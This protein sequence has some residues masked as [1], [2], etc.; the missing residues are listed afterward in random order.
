M[1]YIVIL[2]KYYSDF[3][4]KFEI[5]YEKF[6]FTSIISLYVLY[7]LI[8][9]LLSCCIHQKKNMNNTN[10]MNNNMQDEILYKYSVLKTRLNML[11]ASLEKFTDNIESELNI[12]S[13]K[14]SNMKY[15]IE[16]NNTDTNERI[17]SIEAVVFT[18]EE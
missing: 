5:Q 14:L 15:Q 12:I 17:N 1:D 16:Q 6:L 4:N 2:S 13:N 9:Y 11:S 3:N 8:R 10:S 7:S 18:S